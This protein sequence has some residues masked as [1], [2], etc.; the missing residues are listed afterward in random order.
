MP[1]WRDKGFLIG[2]II[3]LLVFVSG[4]AAIVLRLRHEIRQQEEAILQQVAKVEAGKFQLGQKLPDFSL[5]DAS[6]NQ[7]SLSGALD[8]QHYV[9][10]NFHHPDCPCAANCGALINEMIDAGYSDIKVIGIMSSDTRSER[11]LTALK[12]QQESGEIRFPVYLDHDKTVQNLLGATRTP[13]VWVLDKEG[14]I[15]FYGAPETSLFPGSEGHR[16][17]L[18]E[19]IDAL[20]RDH[21]PEIARFEP[22]GCRI[23]G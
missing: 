22:I 20:R 23:E 13:E 2:I 15:V 8:G 19:A 5:A 11:A 7:F 16:Y 3:F 17:L 21:K 9:V 10:V 6:G 4:S 18:R 14:K 1:L 12:R